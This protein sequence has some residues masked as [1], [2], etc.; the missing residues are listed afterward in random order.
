MQRLTS[1]AEPANGQDSERV[2]SIFKPHNID[3]YDSCYYRPSTLSGTFRPSSTHITS[4]RMIHVII[5]LPPYL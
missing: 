1:T 4:I 5:D 3:L 2:P